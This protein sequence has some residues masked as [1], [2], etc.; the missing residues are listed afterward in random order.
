VIALSLRNIVFLFVQNRAQTTKDDD[1]RMF[2]LVD[3]Y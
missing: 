1:V 3:L 2:S